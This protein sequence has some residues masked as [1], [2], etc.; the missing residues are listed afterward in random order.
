MEARLARLARI[1]VRT[2]Q[3]TAPNH[4][5]THDVAIRPIT[6]ALRCHATPRPPTSLPCRRAPADPKAPPQTS[7]STPGPCR[8]A[9]K[10]EGARRPRGVL[11]TKCPMPNTKYQIPM[12]VRVTVTMRMCAAAHPAALRLRRFDRRRIA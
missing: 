11:N 3:L 6:I 10:Q 1:S 4:Q 12:T 2:L 8:R 7:T 5:R 9:Q